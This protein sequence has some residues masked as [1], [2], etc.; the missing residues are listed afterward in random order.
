MYLVL[1]A[2]VY[3][4]IRSHFLV[5]G[6]RFLNWVWRKYYPRYNIH[7]GLIRLETG[8]TYTCEYEQ[9]P[10]TA[11]SGPI[12]SQAGQ[13]VLLL[14]HLL[15]WSICINSRCISPGLEKHKR[16]S[17]PTMEP[18]TPCFVESKSAG[19]RGHS[20]SPRMEGSTVDCPPT[21]NACRLAMSPT[22]AINQ[23]S[24]TVRRNTPGI[25]NG[26]S[27]HLKEKLS[28]RPFRSSCRPY[29]QLME[30]KD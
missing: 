5:L 7:E 26:C 28:G 15:A 9:T 25:P 8:L 21:I 27:E 10:W 20:G 14:L 1:S 19:S 6:S 4:I 13:L 12:C 2:C 29:P 17:Q 3:L 24:P 18:D 11:G 16:V 22:K 30:D 23:M